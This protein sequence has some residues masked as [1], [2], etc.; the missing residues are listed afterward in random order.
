MAGLERAEDQTHKELEALK[1][2]IRKAEVETEIAITEKEELMERI[3]QGSVKTT[4]DLEELKKKYKMTRKE[5]REKKDEILE[6]E[7]KVTK[8]QEKV[9]SLEYDLAGQK[10][11]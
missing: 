4:E 2:R 5:V 9:A 10:R 6:T 8:L 11:E 7:E 3:E 1:E